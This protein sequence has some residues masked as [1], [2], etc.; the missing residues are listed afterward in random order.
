MLQVLAPIATF[1][2][3]FLNPSLLAMQ[4]TMDFR[5][6]SIPPSCPSNT[7]QMARFGANCKTILQGAFITFGRNMYLDVMEP[8]AKFLDN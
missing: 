1:P 3:P 4:L 8:G 6:D 7:S 2:K 5:V